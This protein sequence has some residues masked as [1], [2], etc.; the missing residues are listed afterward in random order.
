M[1]HDLI[2]E[3]RLHVN[4]H[5]GHFGCV[6]MS[7]SHMHRIIQSRSTTVFAKSTAERVLKELATLKEQLH[8][9]VELDGQCTHFQTTAEK[10]RARLP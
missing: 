3:K 5:N 2:L 4:Q 6:A 9:R 1:P 8:T 7:K 10:E